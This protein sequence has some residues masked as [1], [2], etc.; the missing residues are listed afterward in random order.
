MAFSVKQM[1][2]SRRSENYE[3]HEKYINPQF[4]KVLRTIGFDRGYIKGEGA[5]LYDANGQRF[6]DFLSGYGVF[7][8]GRNHPVIKNAI[9]E[10]IDEPAAHLVQMDCSVYAGLLAEELIKL[11]PS[12]IGK[13]YFTNSGTE[14]VE[15]AI[16]FARGATRRSRIIHCDKAFHGLSMGSLSI[17]GDNHFREGFGDLLPG[18]TKIPFNDLSALEK[19]LSSKDVAAFIVEPIQGKGVNIPDSN[20]LPEAQKLCKKYGTLFVIDEI[21]TGL[22]RTGKLFA[23]EHWGVEPDI[24]T[25]AKALSGG[26]IPVGAALYTND[27]YNKIFTR[28]DR[29]VVHSSTFKQNY[30]AM[31]AG[32]ASLHV[33]KE[34]KLIENAE[35]MGNLFLEKLKPIQEKFELFKSVRGKGLMIALEFADPKSIKL[36]VAWKVIQAAQKGLFAQMVVMPLLEKHKILTQVAGHEVD[37]VK[38]LPPLVITE[39]EVDYFVKALDNVLIDCHKF[40]GAIWDFGSSLVKHALKDKKQ[41]VAN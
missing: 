23:F 5:F 14:A 11:C 1:V 16:K 29:S 38:L 7:N 31:S 6:Y 18:T 34:E 10:M 13:V 37:V 15:T 36:K 21:Q 32:L 35:K 41:K 12:N 19:E 3:L 22:G 4:V 25:I 33:I 20:Y 40:P 2:D 26:Y 30:L 24:I 17:N 28:M 39:N 9:K 27:I 8:M